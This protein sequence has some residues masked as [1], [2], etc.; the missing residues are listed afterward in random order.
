MQKHGT[1]CRFGKEEGRSAA[2]Q[3]QALLVTLP[4]DLYQAN[5][6]EA[7]KGKKTRRGN[8]IYALAV[9]KALGL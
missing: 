2:V 9:Q 7:G 4:L 1:V 3:A 8:A 5:T 6:A